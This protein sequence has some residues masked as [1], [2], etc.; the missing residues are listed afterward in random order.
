MKKSK[1]VI[2]QE[3]HLKNQKPL[4]GVKAEMV[5]AFIKEGYKEDDAYVASCGGV[6]LEFDYK[7][8][9]QIDKMKELYGDPTQKK[10]YVKESNCVEDV[11]VCGISQDGSKVDFMGISF[12]DDVILDA[13]LQ[14]LVEKDGIDLTVGQ[15]KVKDV[16]DKEIRKNVHEEIKKL[17]FIDEMLYGKDGG[18][19]Q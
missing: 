1:L 8:Q 14:K 11:D 2:E 3:A 13:V 6:L 4:S 7:N 5:R 9:Q 16:Y 18:L 12:V 19:T 17:I 10:H 15:V